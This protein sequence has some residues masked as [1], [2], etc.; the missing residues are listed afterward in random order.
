MYP[1]LKLV[2]KVPGTNIDFSVCEYKKELG[3]PYSEVDL[4][5]CLES[6]VENDGE[7]TSDTRGRISGTSPSHSASIES[8]NLIDVSSGDSD[9]ELGF[10]DEWF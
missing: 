5:L 4:F 8:K 3:K 2:R 7:S 1:D 9:L 10:F 6:E